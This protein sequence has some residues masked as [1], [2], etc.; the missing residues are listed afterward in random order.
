MTG[1]LPGVSDLRRLASA[2]S[3]QDLAKDLARGGAAD[4]TLVWALRQT[5]GRGRL[6]RRWK[7]GPGGLYFS[8]VLKPSFAPDRLADFSIM[9]AEAGAE[10]LSRLTGLKLAVKPPNDIMAPGPGG[11]PLKVCG[12]L[13]EACGGASSLDWLVLGAGINVNNR[14][15][16]PP[17]ALPASSLRDLTAKTWPLEAVLRAFLAGFLRRY[18]LFY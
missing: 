6:D 11:A 2:A 18:K 15:R 5:R 13:V 8:L 16:L 7:S 17:D 3:T 12:I 4:G 10:A 1:A 9:T 14:L